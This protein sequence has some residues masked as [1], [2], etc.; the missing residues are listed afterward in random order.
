[1][2]AS[3]SSVRL[4]FDPRICRCRSH[5]KRRISLS[6]SGIDSSF[7]PKRP[8]TK[9]LVRPCCECSTASDSRRICSERARPC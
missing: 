7:S 9:E 8:S 4:N 1:M 6:S 3:P 2:P 5:W